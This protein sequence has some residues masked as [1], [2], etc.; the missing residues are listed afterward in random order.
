MLTYQQQKIAVAL[1][2]ASFGG[3]F[4]IYLLKKLL[5]SEKTRFSFDISGFVERIALTIVIMAGGIYYYLIPLIIILRASII[6]G[7]GT[8]RK[9]ACIISREEPAVEFQ[10]IRSKSELAVS[11][12]S[13]PS[14]GIFIGILA[15]IL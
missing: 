11:L 2:L 3:E 8:F 10:K 5:V 1:L 13:S 7:E 15:K 4:I 14:L 9:I 6:A 12:I